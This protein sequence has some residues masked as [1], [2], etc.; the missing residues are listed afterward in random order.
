MTVSEIKTI[1]LRNNGGV[2]SVWEVDVVPID[3]NI[4][5]LEWLA[6]CSSSESYNVGDVHLE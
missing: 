5:Y 4:F 1:M 3:R 2:G 6:W